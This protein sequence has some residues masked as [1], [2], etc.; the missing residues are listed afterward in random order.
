MASKFWANNSEGEENASDNGDDI[1]H[2]TRKSGRPSIGAS[3]S[4]KMTKII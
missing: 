3:K 2:T 1:V 4:K